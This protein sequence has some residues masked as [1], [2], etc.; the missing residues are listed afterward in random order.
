MYR[1][2]KESK[3]DEVE[4]KTLGEEYKV[5]KTEGRMHSCKSSYENFPITVHLRRNGERLETV[6][7][8]DPFLNEC[9]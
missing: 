3:V 4:R 6:I 9:N 7:R 1:G 8:T 5:R 2:V